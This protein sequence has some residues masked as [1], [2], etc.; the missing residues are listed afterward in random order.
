MCVCEPPSNAHTPSLPT[1]ERLGSV[2]PASRSLYW[3]SSV[4]S[5]QALNTRCLWRWRPVLSPAESRV[6][7]G[8]WV[9]S[10]LLSSG[11]FGWGEAALTT[12]F[13]PQKKIYGAAR[14]ISKDLRFLI[15]HNKTNCPQSEAV[16]GCWLWPRAWRQQNIRSCAATECCEREPD[17]R[18]SRNSRNTSFSLTGAGWAHSPPPSTVTHWSCVHQWICHTTTADNNNRSYYYLLITIF[19]VFTSVV[20]KNVHNK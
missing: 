18:N 10:S 2:L 19:R 15:T 8:P 14:I 20:A 16:Q 9:S 4:F 12:A 7:R 13:T 17:Y 11:R 1:E 3:C 6:R 5:A